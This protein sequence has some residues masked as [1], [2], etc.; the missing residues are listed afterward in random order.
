MMKICVHNRQ[1]AV[2]ERKRYFARKAKPTSITHSV[3]ETMFYKGTDYTNHENDSAEAVPSRF[4]SY[5]ASPLFIKKKKREEKIR[6][7]NV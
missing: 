5:I 2:W 7:G 1:T 3:M 6:R 4:E